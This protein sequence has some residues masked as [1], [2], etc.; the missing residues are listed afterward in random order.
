[1]PVVVSKGTHSCPLGQLLP[2]TSQLPSIVVGIKVGFAVLVDALVTVEVVTRALVVGCAVVML[3]LAVVIEAV[4]VV[5]S[6]LVGGEHM[7]DAK[8]HS[9][10]VHVLAKGPL[11]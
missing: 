4:E 7:S 3:G 1:M 2:N 10:A 11:F 5:T 6:G 9:C 8:E